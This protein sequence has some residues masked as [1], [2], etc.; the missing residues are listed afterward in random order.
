[1][2]NPNAPE[3]RNNGRRVGR[4]LSDVRPRTDFDPPMS[5][6]TARYSLREG[7]QPR[8]AALGDRKRRSTGNQS[9]H[10][11][12]EMQTIPSKSLLL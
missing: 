10:R 3:R 1:M 11:D 8:A 6:N 12:F 5:R 4:S 2:T 9:V 7:G